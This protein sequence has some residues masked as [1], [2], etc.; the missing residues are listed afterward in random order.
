[1][2]SGE[3]EMM[4]EFDTAW[5]DEIRED[6]L[7]PLVGDN[8]SSLC[9]CTQKQRKASKNAPITSLGSVTHVV[10]AVPSGML[11][12]IVLV[13]LFGAIPGGSGFN[14]RRNRAVPFP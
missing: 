14:A 5:I 9:T 6:A 12:Q 1:M 4:R 11:A 7:I 3:A 10:T 8:R 2:F 13:I